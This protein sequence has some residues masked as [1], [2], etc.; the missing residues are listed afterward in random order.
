MLGMPLEDMAHVPTGQ[1]WE[2]LNK[3]RQQAES[4]EMEAQRAA[5]NRTMR[6]QV[7][8]LQSL[9]SVSA[10]IPVGSPQQ[11]QNPESSSRLRRHFLPELE[12][13]ENSP[14]RYRQERALTPPASDSEVSDAKGNAQIRRLQKEVIERESKIEKLESELQAEKDERRQLQA[15]RHEVVDAQRKAEVGLG[16]LE[17]KVANLDRLLDGSV[18]REK[19][20]ERALD[21]ARQ[22]IAELKRRLHDERCSYESDIR[23]RDIR[24]RRISQQLE[25]TYCALESEIQR[26]RRSGRDVRSVPESETQCERSPDRVA[27]RK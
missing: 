11:F 4:R 16:R 8:G 21:A 26:D 9:T 22:E 15:E 12:A 3:K 19:E 13:Q 5:A 7:G 1:Y 10:T 27:D 17:A 2:A 20:L 14:P 18:Q 24:E 25:D 6:A 23:A